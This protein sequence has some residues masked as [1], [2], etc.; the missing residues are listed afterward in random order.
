MYSPQF[1]WLHTQGGDRK[2][3]ATEKEPT[4]S[5]GDNLSETLNAQGIPVAPDAA[6]ETNKQRF[7]QWLRLLLYQLLLM[8]TQVAICS[9]NEGASLA[10][11]R[12]GYIQGGPEFHPLL[13][14]YM[15]QT[16]RCNIH[17]VECPG[18][19]ADAREQGGGVERGSR[20]AAAPDGRSREAGQGGAAVPAAAGAGRPPALLHP[21]PL[22]R[23]RLPKTRAMPCLFCPTA[24]REHH[25]SQLQHS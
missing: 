12:L 7:T 4:A 5:G 23:P 11:V 25:V 9:K 2:P 24:S 16:S 10:Q 8:I 17:L 20:S 6:F 22:V 15:Q 21:L 13:G 19:A 14:P 3:A 18:F 1:W